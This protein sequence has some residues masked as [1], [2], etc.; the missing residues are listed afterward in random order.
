MQREVMQVL[1]MYRALNIAKVRGWKPSDASKAGFQGFDAN[2]E[3]H[4]HYAHHILDV[5][6]LFAESAPN[7]NSHGSTTMSDYLPMLRAWR[8]APNPFALSDAEAEAVITA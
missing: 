5:A 8:K 1:D 7:K 3:S 4:Y 2:N 6:N